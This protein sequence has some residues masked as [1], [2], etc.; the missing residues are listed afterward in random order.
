MPSARDQ[1]LS[2]IDFWSDTEWHFLLSVLLHPL[3]FV[4]GLEG[5]AGFGSVSLVCLLL[6]CP[7]CIR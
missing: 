5:D 1:V 6:L 3:A 7:V 2:W 4:T